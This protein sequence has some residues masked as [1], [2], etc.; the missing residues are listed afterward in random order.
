MG[1]TEGSSALS[2][3]DEPVQCAVCN[4]PCENMATIGFDHV[5]DDCLRDY[6]QQESVVED[7]TEGFIERFSEDFYWKW[8]WDG[9]AYLTDE[10]K[11]EILK[12]AFK[13]RAMRFPE[14][15]RQA[16]MEYIE[17]NRPEWEGYIKEG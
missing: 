15:T 16:Q 13:L 5:C 3:P 2:I 12:T 8:W 7:Y 17:T 14:Q 4:E 6:C 10:D 11:L 9:D 1:Y